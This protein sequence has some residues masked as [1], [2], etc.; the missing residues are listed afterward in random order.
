MTDNQLKTKLL[1]L[2]EHEFLSTVAHVAIKRDGVASSICMMATLI[3]K[4]RAASRTEDR[5]EVAEALR[6][7]ADVIERPLFSFND[8]RFPEGA[9]AAGEGAA[10]T[11]EQDKHVPDTKADL[12]RTTFRFQ[13][14]KPFPSRR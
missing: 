4:L 13:D 6:N 12:S 8:Y 7:T 5:A 1:R 9:G 14:T 11:S 2:T 3:E 10:Q